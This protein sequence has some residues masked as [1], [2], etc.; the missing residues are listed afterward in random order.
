[1]ESEN[2]RHTAPLGE[3]QQWLQ[4]TYEVESK[5]YEGKKEA[6]HLELQN[7]KDMVCF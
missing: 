3:L 4:L 2:H 1:V 5:Y 6:A 7:A